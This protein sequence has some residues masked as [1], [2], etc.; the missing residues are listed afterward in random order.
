MRGKA[1]WEMQE[2]PGSPPH[3]GAGQ[4]SS[5]E[6]SESSDD[7]SSEGERPSR[8][9][10]ESLS[11]SQV[12]GCE[13]ASA[14]GSEY[15]S[16]EESAGADEERVAADGAADVIEEERVSVGEARVRDGLARLGIPVRPV[17]WR[18]PDPM[19]AFRAHVADRAAQRASAAAGAMPSERAAE[20]PQAPPMPPVVPAVPSP[21]SA[22]SSVDT[23]GFQL[24]RPPAAPL[25]PAPVG[26]DLDAQVAELMARDPEAGVALALA[27]FRHLPTAALA[28]EADRVFGRAPGM[29]DG[30]HADAERA[31]EAVGQP[32]AREESTTLAVQVRVANAP[33]AIVRRRRCYCCDDDASLAV[34][35]GQAECAALRLLDSLEADLEARDQIVEQELADGFDEE[36]THRG[37]RWFMYRTFVARQ[38]GYLGAGVRVR[39]PDCVIAAIRL[40][41]RAPGCTCDVQ[42]IA[43]CNRYRGHRDTRGS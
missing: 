11:D 39:I 37:A 3:D 18:N 28:A 26:P 8:S 14:S 21:P 36:A 9:S 29:V 15:A 41:Y 25:Q 10:D 32:R 22:G 6:E 2:S 7:S 13:S 38:F 34:G 31:P 1:L 20:E 40:R 42:A 5:S 23:G 19:E 17:G 12:V 30:R 35:N 24:R 4:L 43:T 16:A 27:I 33:V